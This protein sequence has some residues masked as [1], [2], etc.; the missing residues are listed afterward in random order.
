[1]DELFERLFSREGSKALIENAV[2][3][4]MMTVEQRFSR[5]VLPVERIPEHVAALLSEPGIAERMRPGMRIAITASSRGIANAALILK[6]IVDAV[7]T[8]GAIPFIV[9]AMGSHGGATAE[10]QRAILAEY[11]ITEESMGCG[12]DASMEVVRVGCSE[13]GDEVS[14]AKCAAE[15]DGIIL[16]CRIKPHTSFRGPYES[17]IMKMMAIGLG[18]QAGAEACH[19]KGFANMAKMVPSFGRVILKN[20]P[21]LFAVACIENAFD[22]T[23]EIHAVAAEDI[24]EREPQLLK[25]AFENMP[26]IHAEDCDILIVDRVGKDISGAGVDPNVTGIQCTPYVSGGL[27]S[28][29]VVFLDVTDASHGNPGNLG[30]ADVTTRRAVEKI[31]LDTVYVNA[32]TYKLLSGNGIPVFMDND[33]DAIRL[34]LK[35]CFS[36]NPRIIRIQDSL[37]VSRIQFSEAYLQEVD[38]NPILTRLTEPEPM[39]FDGEGNLL[40]IC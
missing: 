33:R 23:A 40:P 37:H 8:R 20:A 2:L 38:T 25:R 19:R 21:I 17:G 22:E 30:L 39:A 5:P 1:M 36:D 29:Y 14:I 32:I 28:Q 6:T 26:R 11:G 10:G 34:A 12:I 4:K 35:F 16:N 27:K 24:C 15:A 18:K 9:P 3:P 13:D 7:K 31:C